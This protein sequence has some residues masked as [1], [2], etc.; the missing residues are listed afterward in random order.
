MAAC[1]PGGGEQY[2]VLQVAEA[3]LKPR[4]RGWPGRWPRGGRGDESKR[5]DY[6]EW[7]RLTHGPRRSTLSAANEDV[8]VRRVYGI[9][10]HPCRLQCAAAYAPCLVVDPLAWPASPECRYAY[11]RSGRGSSLGSVSAEILSSASTV[12]PQASDVSARSGSAGSV[13]L[14]AR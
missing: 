14:T 3:R 12:I 8:S 5:P 6:P 11:A 9:S 2:L 13:K 4:I 1:L 10:S 7:L